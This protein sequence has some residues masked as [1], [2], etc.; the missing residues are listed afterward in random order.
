[1]QFQQRLAGDPHFLGGPA[2]FVQHG[3][4]PRDLLTGLFGL[5][6]DLPLA[7]LQTYQHRPQGQLPAGHAPRQEVALP[8]S[9]RAITSLI[10]Q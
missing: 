9:R 7:L 3:G 6:G 5:L 8:V 1:M 4:E 2:E 10:A